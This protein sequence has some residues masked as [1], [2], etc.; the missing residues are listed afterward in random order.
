MSN[1]EWLSKPIYLNPKLTDEEMIKSIFSDFSRLF[2]TPLSI[3]G[4]DAVL[5][6][7]EKITIESERFKHFVKREDKFHGDRYWDYE[8]ATRIW[9]IRDITVNYK[10]NRLMIW[11]K[12]HNRYMRTYILLKDDRYLLILDDRHKFYFIVTAY[13]V[14]SDAKLGDYMFEYRKYKKT[15]IVN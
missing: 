14:H 7:G 10:D 8:R 1:I 13:Y 3:F 6:S 12:Q 11:K 5:S 2:H 9:W 4:I 15:Q